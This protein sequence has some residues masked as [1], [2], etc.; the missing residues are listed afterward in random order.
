VSDAPASPPSPEAFVAKITEL[1]QFERG[2]VALY[3]L[4]PDEALA[5][6]AQRLCQLHHSQSSLEPGVER[7]LRANEP[8]LAAWTEASATW[9]S[10]LWEPGEIMATFG[11]RVIEGLRA[12]PEVWGV[13]VDPQAQFFGLAAA[14]DKDDEHRFWLVLVTGRKSGAA[15]PE[16]ATAAR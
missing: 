15:G 7:E 4:L 13:I 8:L 9:R 11:F 3:Y 12:Q 14:K 10:D 2:I 1:V 16:M 6:Q 5:Q